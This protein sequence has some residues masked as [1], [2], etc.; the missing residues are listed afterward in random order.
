M[1]I[2]DGVATFDQVISKFPE[3][4][5]LSKPKAIIECYENIACNP[6]STSCPFNA[7][8]IGEDI[9]NIP[10]VDFEK[11]TGCGICAY[12]C[13]GLAIIVARIKENKALFKI[14]YEFIPA[15]NK[16]DIW[17]AVN[18]KGE[19]I[20]DAFIEK[21]DMTIKQ[22]KTLLVHVVVDKDLIYDFVTIRRKEDE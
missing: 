13:P 1:L 18:R 16:G 2:K 7:I 11:C 22:D 9:N 5:I 17:Y 4:D 21:V 12:S 19:I 6:C 20:G 15:P 8:T 3:L 14:P 10:K